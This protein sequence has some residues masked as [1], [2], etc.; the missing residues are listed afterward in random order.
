MRTQFFP[1]GTEEVFKRLSRDLRCEEDAELEAKFPAGTKV[2][3]MYMDLDG[4]VRGAVRAVDSYK[5]W[6]T[7]FLRSL[8]LAH[9]TQQRNNLRDP[10]VQNYGGVLCDQLVG[11]A[12]DIHD[13][14]E[15]MRAQL[16]ASVPKAQ[17]AD[18][19][20]ALPAAPPA[21]PAAPSS[22]ATA[23]PSFAQPPPT[24]RDFVSMADISRESCIDGASQL[25]LE[26]GRMRPVSE[27]RKGDRAASLPSSAAEVVCVV[28]TAVPEGRA[29][30]VHLPGGLRITSW[31]P[32]LDDG[33]WRFPADLAPAVDT[34][35]DA[36]YTFILSGGDAVVVGGLP[37][38]TLGHRQ[39]EGAAKHPYF[40]SRHVVD[41]LGRVPGFK[42]GLVDLPRSCWARDPLT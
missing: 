9:L 34:A 23:A 15:H 35:C 37:C 8:M 36:V 22:A 31:H 4:Q 42:D 33:S 10:G 19:S 17:P 14:L 13:N 2:A 32:V 16:D 3:R 39:E 28:R 40:G 24:P 20:S 11:E 27:I 12:H 1:E 29:S 7:N 41:D 6:G 25:R 21:Q 38:L 18:P 30:L 5:R 26:D